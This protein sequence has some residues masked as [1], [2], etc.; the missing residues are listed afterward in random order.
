V[1]VRNLR[2]LVPMQNTA[3]SDL[4]VFYLLA[5]YIVWVLGW[6]SF[7]LSLRCFSAWRRATRAA[8]TDAYAANICAECSICKDRNSTPGIHVKCEV[9]KCAGVYNKTF[10]VLDDTIKGVIRVALSLRNG[11]AM[12]RFRVCLKAEIASRLQILH[13][14]ASQDAIEYKKKI[15]RLFLSHGRSVQTRRILL[16]LCPNGD[17][18]E[19][20]VQFYVDLGGPAALTNRRTILQHITSLGLHMKFVC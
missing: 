6:G 9:H 18:R 1:L 11:A 7:F 10:S 19:S 15:L 17:W 20:N 12:A 14:R 8:T 13:G 2:K 3:H 4:S 16:I 5:V